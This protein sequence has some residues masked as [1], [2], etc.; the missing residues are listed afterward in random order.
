[1]PRSSSTSLKREQV[2]L[3]TSPREYPTTHLG[4]D[5]DMHFPSMRD[6]DDV[7]IEALD[8]DFD[9]GM[10]RDDDLHLNRPPSNG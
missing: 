2:K 6:D 10:M 5:T 9:F 8:G 4:D 3:S 1:M 7:S